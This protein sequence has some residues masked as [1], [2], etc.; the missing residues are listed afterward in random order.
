MYREEIE[1]VR[2]KIVSRKRGVIERARSVSE[3]QRSGKFVPL[4]RPYRTYGKTQVP[5]VGWF[6]LPP[7]DPTIHTYSV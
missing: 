3:K 6:Y 5:V 7:L 4:I 1:I 2:K